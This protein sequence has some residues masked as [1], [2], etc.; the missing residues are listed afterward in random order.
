[1]DHVYVSIDLEMT[2]AHP[3][4]QEILEI[5][6][7]KFR[8]STI[9]DSWS[10]LVNPGQQIPY[11]IQVLTG[12]RQEDVAKA[13][14]I[15][16]V[17]AQLI[18]FVGNHPLVAHSVSSDIGCLRRKGIPL[19]N[20]Q[21]DTYELATIL[22][23]SL[24]S[25]SLES[26]AQHL[27]VSFRKSHRAADDALT[28]VEVLN[29]LLER[30]EELDLS[31]LQEINKLVAKTNWAL[32]PI[33]L[34]VERR[35]SRAAFGGTSIRQQLAAKAGLVEAALDFS[36]L[37]DA[38]NEPL[39]PTSTRQPLDVDALERML[40]AGGL[41]AT[42]FPG[43]ESRPEQMQMLRA[44][45]NAF[46]DSTNL[47]VEAGTGTG[48]SLAYLLPAIY[49]AAQNGE[50]VVVS[51]NTINLQDQ[52]YGK[53]IPDL[54]RLLPVQFRACLV[55]GRSNYLC[56]SRWAAVRRQEFREQEIMTLVKVLTWL[57]N[58]RTG[59]VS[60][61]G[62]LDE[63]EMH[64]WTSLSAAYESC[65][66]N[67]CSYFRKGTC[68]VYRARR[69][70]EASHIIIVNH[71][72]LLSDLDSGGV[73]PD[74]R[75]LIIDEA[76]HLEEEATEQLGFVVKKNDLRSLLDELSHTSSSEK[77]SGL[78]ADMK[79]FFRGSKVPP[80]VQKDVESLAAELRDEVEQV[81]R[82]GDVLF[83]KLAAHLLQNAR[84]SRGYEMRLRLTRSQRVQPSWSEIEI[85][86]DSLAI[87]LR[88]LKDG[89]SK[90]LTVFGELENHKILDYDNLM[91]QLQHSIQRAQDVFNRTVTTI[92][93][94]RSD[95]V[96]WI[97]SAPDRD[98]VS[99]HSAP[100]H[101][102]SLLQEQL[103]SRKESVVLTSA[104]LS[105]SGS[106]AYTKERLGF[107][108]AEELLVGSPFD[109]AK[110]TMLYIP[111]DM[112][113]PD[114]PYYQK[115]LQQAIVDLCK[116]THGRT[117]ILFT[118]HSQLRQTWQAI[119]HP[120]A[121]RGILVLGHKVDGM[122]RRQL[123]Q[124]FKTNPKTVLL[125]ASSFWEG[126]DVVGDALSVLV[127]TRLP[128]AVP[129][130]PIIAARSELF[131][132]PFHQYSLPQAILRFKQ[133]FGRLIRS[134]SDRGV[135][136]VLD[137]RIHSK[138]YGTSVLRSLPRCTV[139]YG[140]LTT[141]SLE[142]SRWLTPVTPSSS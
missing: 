81:R 119:R 4:N 142:A 42:S 82:F 129:S 91:A 31:V 72:L 35:K 96:Y 36:Y 111:E 47:L 135:V 13:P 46:N 120:L 127:I 50:H 99:L 83:E 110:S 61:I 86:C 95:Y 33:F 140:P 92:S 77:I 98:D 104:T 21:V 23:P 5:A 87:H 71:A 74:Y 24:P 112:P 113:E 40:A 118:S 53:D 133:G 63:E 89:L 12:I 131:D 141:L 121:E 37:G 2:S 101:V 66:G 51:T 29:R 75:Y 85:C 65:S 22:L 58:T 78:L 94:P 102:G 137:S 49:F 115:S 62:R 80:H 114:R 136:V 138:S 48:K 105:I 107:E 106:F 69:D 100:L 60:E 134:K 16:Q 1:M 17:A 26:V 41:L 59:D 70:A 44:V 55:K 30:A 109:Y 56:L 64:T 124:T 117:L 84:D 11:S 68:F 6:A 39:S 14:S 116:A 88:S 27:E 126:V 38:N 7:V 20:Q 67:Q 103:F 3:E 132:D 73:L 45:S 130:D 125:G 34:E 57:P 9:L 25:Y 90:L 139:K 93:N 79:P 54:Q 97:S 76:H 128:F 15:Q 123:L 52:L 8:G 43:F 19:D 10:T 32:K 18:K 28:T 122:P 108:D